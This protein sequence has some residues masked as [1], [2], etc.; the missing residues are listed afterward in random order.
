MSFAASL[1]DT[2]VGRVELVPLIL[3]DVLICC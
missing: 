3:K 2:V 1:A